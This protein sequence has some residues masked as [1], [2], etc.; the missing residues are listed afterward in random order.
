MLPTPMFPRVPDGPQPSFFGPDRDPEINQRR[1][2][3][4][5]RD[6]PGR[7]TPEFFKP[8][9]WRAA[10]NGGAVFYD[11]TY[12]PVA[13]APDPAIEAARRQLTPAYLR[14]RGPREY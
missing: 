11:P 1:V 9:N 2:V 14:R 5:F 6:L 10:S 3:N 12:T 7:V 4:F 13:Y 8:G